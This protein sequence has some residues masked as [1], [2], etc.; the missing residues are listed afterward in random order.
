MDILGIILIG[1]VIILALMG[2]G[3]FIVIAIGVSTYYQVDKNKSA[4]QHDD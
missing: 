3:S 4:I 1:I 2:I